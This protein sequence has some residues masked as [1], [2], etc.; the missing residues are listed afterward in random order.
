[1]AKNIAYLKEML[2]VPIIDG[3]SEDVCNQ[4]D[5]YYA[6]G[7]WTDFCGLSDEEM[8]KAAIANAAGSSEC[9]GGGGDTGN[10]GTS[11]TENII[12]ITSEKDGEK[13]TLTATAE[14]E[15]DV[16]VTIT[17]PYLILYP[18]G[19][20]ESKQTMIKILNGK[21]IGRVEIV[22]ESGTVS[23]IKNNITV[24][25]KTSD[26]F[27]FEVDNQTDIKDNSI[28]YGTARYLE[29]EEYGI[30]AL[31]YSVLG[32]FSEVHISE[33]TVE[34]SSK[35]AAEEVDNYRGQPAIRDAHAYD[36]V[37][38]I[39][40]DIDVNDLIVT[41]LNGAGEGDVVHFDESIGSIEYDDELYAAYRLT[42]H[43]AWSVVTGPGEVSEGYE[44]KYKIQ[45]K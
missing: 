11:K 25:P 19:T 32:E 27:E 21:K 10:T 39:D 3:Q 42:N 29:M 23:K 17:I 45:Q 8:R 15:V 9:C 5:R 24:E 2:E 40:A 7:M 12:T 18:D 20:T 34:I 30:D 16:D 28:L 41:D 33:E 36:F 37:F 4:D 26:S 43:V 1:M 31:T 13:C 22:P 44:W 35:R 38:L 14:Q 6:F